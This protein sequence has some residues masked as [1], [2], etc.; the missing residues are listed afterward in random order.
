MTESEF[1]HRLHR[2]VNMSPVLANEADL[3]FERGG[4]IQQFVQRAFMSWGINVSARHRIV[5]FLLITWV[6]L[7]ILA[8]IEGRAIQSEPSASF[9]LDFGTYARFFV[10]VPLL[11]VAES[12]VGPRLT[13][14]G[15]HFVQGGFVRPEDYPAFD[16]A[17]A[18]VKKLRES[19][20]VELM[21]L[22]VAIA[23]AWLL[24]T[25]TLAGEGLATWRSPNAPG[26]G[27]GVSLTAL[28]YR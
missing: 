1:R 19:L 14:A 7:L 23:G 22:G 2:E 13:G 20:F 6:P 11:I 24:T 10:A 3:Y 4:P 8:W 28:W 27:L 25:E 26:T 18:H 15:L 5:G 9:L 17:I 16:Q 12:V 21:I